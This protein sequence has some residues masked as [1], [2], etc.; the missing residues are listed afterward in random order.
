MKTLS[1]L[2]LLK[3]QPCFPFDS[4]YSY[5]ICSLADYY[6]SKTNGIERIQHELSQWDAAARAY[7]LDRV[8]EEIRDYGC[9]VFEEDLIF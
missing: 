2:E 4:A 7:I 6:I 1:D 5:L 3:T 8:I 9:L